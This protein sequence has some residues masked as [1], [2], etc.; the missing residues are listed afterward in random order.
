MEGSAGE[1]QLCA[2]VGNSQAGAQQEE[3][4]KHLGWSALQ[5]DV[6]EQG[7]NHKNCNSQSTNSNHFQ[8]IV[9]EHDREA[10]FKNPDHVP[11]PRRKVEMLELILDVIVSNA[12]N[13]N[14]GSE[15]KNG[16]KFQD[17][18]HCKDHESE[19]LLNRSF[20]KLQKQLWDLTLLC[21]RKEVKCLGGRLKKTNEV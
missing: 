8:I 6:G 10:E 14:D 16:K 21:F 3:G 20:R 15:N 12:P 19:L 13:K 2:H 4:R 17:K 18:R 11:D 7:G 9:E 1:M 5:S